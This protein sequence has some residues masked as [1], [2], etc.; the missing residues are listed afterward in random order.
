[1]ADKKRE[2]LLQDE[3]ISWLRDWSLKLNVTW[4]YNSSYCLK[5]I[6]LAVHMFLYKDLAPDNCYCQYTMCKMSSNLGWEIIC[7][8]H[9]W[10][11]LQQFFVRFVTFQFTYLSI[12]IPIYCF[13]CAQDTVRHGTRVIEWF[14][15]TLIQ[16]ETGSFTV[17]EHKTNTFVCLS[18][19]VVY[20]HQKFIHKSSMFIQLHKCLCYSS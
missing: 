7:E 16:L 3:T 10:Q 18:K 6:R 11:S 9:N 20:I 2:K 14:G 8:Y 15:Y 19:Y 17:L 13:K 4:S 1:M 12:Y 5:V